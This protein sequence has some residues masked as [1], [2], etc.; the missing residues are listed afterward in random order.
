MA[1]L[2][3]RSANRP[4]TPLLLGLGTLLALAGSLG[5]FLEMPL[6][7]DRTAG[8]KAIIAAG[9]SLPGDVGEAASNEQRSKDLFITGPI[10]AHSRTETAD[11]PRH[12]VDA[13]TSDQAVDEKGMRIWDVDT[14]Q[15]VYDFRRPVMKRR[16]SA[17]STDGRTVAETAAD[18][19]IDRQKI[20]SGSTLL[21]RSSRPWPD[22]DEITASAYTQSDPGCDSEV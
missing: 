10:K 4:Y 13:V 2:P 19:V 7:S 20:D 9:C 5:W 8:V 11:R 14:G 15:V 17:I 6:L 18:G 12:V 22:F 3:Y 16:D 21:N 1:E